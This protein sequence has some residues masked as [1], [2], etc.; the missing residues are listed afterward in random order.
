[1]RRQA[2]RA[3]PFALLARRS[4][5]WN[6]RRL[7]FCFGVFFFFLLLLL[8]IQVYAVNVQA[9]SAQKDSTRREKRIDAPTPPY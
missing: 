7:P 9:L 5:G 4:G 1:M 3:H 8:L 2:T 6:E